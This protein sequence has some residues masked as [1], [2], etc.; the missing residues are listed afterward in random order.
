[1]SEV[2]VQTDDDGLEEQDQTVV[3]GETDDTDGEP[4]DFAADAEHDDD[5]DEDDD[6]TADDDEPRE[7]ENA[8]LSEKEREKRWQKIDAEKVRHAKR[9]GEIM[10]DDATQLIPCPV[11]M[12]GMHGWIFPPEVAPLDDT[13]IARIRQVIGLPDL[14]TFMDDP[15]ARRCDA[16]GGLGKVKTGSNVPGYEV[17]E[18]GKCLSK[19]W[20]GIRVDTQTGVIDDIPPAA[21]TGPTVYGTNDEDPEVRKLRERGFT[22]IPPM[23]IVQQGV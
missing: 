17:R 12:D 20:V 8:P 15:E 1:M 22:V 6:D 23:P 11:C 16:C 3:Q 10:G 19:G 13:A 9:L 5:D 21:V 7:D 18:C 4:D 2:A 14:T